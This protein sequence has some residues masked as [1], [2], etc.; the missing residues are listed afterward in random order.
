ME[1]RLGLPAVFAISTGAMFSSGFFLLPGF[2]A[3]ETGPSV[4]LAYLVA[5]VLVLPALLSLA[6]LSSAMP[7]A[8]GPYYFLARGLGPLAGT[9]GALGKYLQLVFKGAFA[10]VGVGAYLSLVV[11]APIRPIALGLV[12]VFTVVNLLGTGST[13]RTEIGLVA[14]LL[15]LLLYI[16]ISGATELL[17]VADVPAERFSPLFAFGAGGFVSAVALVFVS[18]AGVGQVASL[19]EEVK[20]PARTVPRGMLLALATATLF[21]VA[22]TAIM[23]GLVAPAQLHDDPAPV[24]TVVERF[25][26]L[27]LPVMVVVVAALA[28]FVSTGNAAILSAARYPLAMARDGLLWQRFADLD[29]R[30]VPRIA[31]VTTGAAMAA[32]ILLFDVEGIAKL[33]SAFLLLVF[34]GVCLV[35]IVFRESRLAEYE[36][37]FRMPWYPWTPASGIV[38][39]LVLIA[40]SGAQALVMLGSLLIGSLLWYRHGIRQRTTSS[41]VVH[42]LFARLAETEQHGPRAHGPWLSQVAD[43]PV[44][45]L[46]A[47]AIVLEVEDPDDLRAVVAQAAQAL[48]HRIGGDTDALTEQLIDEVRP[49]TRPSTTGIA[50][51]PALL[52]G[53]EQPE[54]VLMRV[55][56]GP[57]VAGDTLRGLIVVVDDETAAARLLD[58]VGRITSSIELPGF[59]RTWDAAE[60]PEQ[61]RAA[62]TRGVITVRLR[63]GEDRGSPHLAGI[64]LRDLDLPDGSLVT[65]IHREG[66]AVIPSGDERLDEGDLVTVLAHADVAD[67]VRRRLG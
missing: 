23:V 6:E 44:A 43:E 11:A 53:I 29:R 38:A 35:V 13:A 42:R 46:T 61:L 45:Q 27:P 51:A 30:G 4:P 59:A 52:P 55:R 65:M 37:G 58:V 19:S 7:R 48:A 49:W 47:R 5:G 40:E 26:V 15:V 16:S 41:A 34:A 39:Y 50:V 54:M 18:F 66:R 57:T 20:E 36:P 62:P 22:G 8:G 64:R 21:Y 24:A 28:A 2:A 25:T 56:G 60:G 3:D 33:A 10:F 12:L 9:I 31:V 67:E 63:I 17:V 14:V 32:S 1:R